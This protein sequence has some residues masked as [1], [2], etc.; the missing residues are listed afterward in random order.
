MRPQTTESADRSSGAAN[1]SAP[2]VYC[3][4]P[5]SDSDAVI[6]IEG[7]SVHYGTLVAV[8]GLDLELRRGELFGLIGP[9]GA[10][11]STTLRVLI[12]QRTPSAGK[13]TVLGRDIV[14]E[15]SAIKPHFGYVPDR[16]NHFEELSGRRNLA[17]FAGLYRVDMARVEEC[18][19]LVELQ[20]AADVPVRSFSLGMRRKLLLAR[21]LL[22]KPPIM[23]LDEPTANLDVRSAG[24]VHDILRERAA[25]GCTVLMTTHDMREVEEVCSR[26][27]ILCDGKVVATGAPRE[28]SRE[29]HTAD[30]RDAFLEMT[31]RE[32]E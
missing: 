17:L 11:K 32:P 21:A 6:R 27:A 28:L 23:Y 10:G 30:F 5:V 26:V 9:N 22:H 3:V 20:H 7:L 4:P 29:A 31:G 24:I 16:D 18:L 14:L 1:V 15:W 19:R 12:G 13:A 2:A 25:E 8:D